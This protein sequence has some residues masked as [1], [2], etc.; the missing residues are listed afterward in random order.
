M[1]EIPALAHNIPGGKQVFNLCREYRYDEGRFP[2][3]VGYFPVTD[4]EVCVIVKA[5]ASSVACISLSLKC[6]QSATRAHE[7]L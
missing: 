1:H 3:G 7:L 5:Y 4:H 6:L 2:N